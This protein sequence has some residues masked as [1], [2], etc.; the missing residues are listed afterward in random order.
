MSAKK[1]TELVKADLSNVKDLVRQALQ[2]ER[3]RSSLGPRLDKE[4]LRDLLLQ[5]MPDEVAGRP[6]PVQILSP[7]ET[8]KQLRDEMATMQRSL[9]WTLSENNRLAARLV[10]LEAELLTVKP[11]LDSE[12]EARIATLEAEL[13]K[14]K[15]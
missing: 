9:D 3:Q 8:E 2:E 1:K 4:Q 6:G 15:S 12:R 14:L 10:E 11:Q 7:F 13:Q 5:L